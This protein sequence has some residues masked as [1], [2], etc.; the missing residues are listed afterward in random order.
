MNKLIQI[1]NTLTT[2]S[3]KGEDTL[4]MADCLR[5]LRQYILENQNNE[6]EKTEE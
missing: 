4:T 5:A 6:V 3:T 2:I 1:Y